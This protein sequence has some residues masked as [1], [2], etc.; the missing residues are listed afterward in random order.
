MLKIKDNVDLKELEK[1]PF[2]YEDSGHFSHSDKN[3]Q[4]HF[5]VWKHSRKI[6]FVNG[7]YPHG[8]KI[9]NMMKKDG[10]VE[11]VDDNNGN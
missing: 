5:N 7:E 11:E 1:Y 2:E 10:I 9:L 4:H 8:I 3:C 6:E